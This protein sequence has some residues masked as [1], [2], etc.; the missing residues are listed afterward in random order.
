MATAHER[1]LMV[2]IRAALSPDLLAPEYAELR[3]G[4]RG[5]GRGAKVRGHCYAASEALYHL[6]GGARAGWSPCQGRVEGTSHWWL[7][8]D[9][10]TVLD[11]TAAQFS[12]RPDYAAGTRRGF[13]TREPSARA[14]E[15]LARMGERVPRRR[16]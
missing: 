1:D 8:H 7:E 5:K 15:V 16:R 4:K 3:A 9:D 12:Q 6:L 11:V 14:R 13:L 2:R 10:G